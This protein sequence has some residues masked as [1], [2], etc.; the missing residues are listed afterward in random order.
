MPK[1][2]MEMIMEIDCGQHKDLC[3]LADSTNPGLLHK[4]GRLLEVF[5]EM[6]VAALVRY[7]CQCSCRA[8]SPAQP[9]TPPTITPT[10][11]PIPA[12]ACQSPMT[13]SN[14]PQTPPGQAV[15]PAPTPP[16]LPT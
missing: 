10:A 1:S 5:S 16:A 4:V 3:C 7:A 14:T 12:P 11:A 9:T 6:E 13:A 2:M 8:T 15:P